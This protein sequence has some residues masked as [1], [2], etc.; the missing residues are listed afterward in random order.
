MVI[1]NRKI[2]QTGL[3]NIVYDKKILFRIPAFY[4]W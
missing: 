4:F 3:N 2:P 1:I